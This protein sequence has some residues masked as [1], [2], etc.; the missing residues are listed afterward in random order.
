MYYTAVSNLRGF[1][2]I[3][4]NIL[5][6][7][8][9]LPFVRNYF[10]GIATIFML[11][12]VAPLEKNK[13]F[14]TERMK[15][16]PEFLANFTMELRNNG[17][18]I[19]GIDKLY[20]LLQ[21]QENVKKQIVF[22]LDDGYKDTFE[23]AYPVFKKLNVPFTVYIT[24]SFPN[25]NALLW[26]YVLEDLLLEKTE[27]EID[28]KVYR[29]QNQDE[30]NKTFLELLE[31]VSRI[32][33]QN[34]LPGLE[35]IF[36]NYKLDWFARNDELCM[37]W[38][39]IE[40]LSRDPLCTIGSHTRNHDA[41]NRLSNDLIVE[42]IIKANDELERHINRKI[43]HFAYPFGTVNEVGKREM[44]IVKKLGFKTVVTARYGSIYL[45]H[46]DYS[47]CCLPRI[48]LSENFQIKNIGRIRRK[49]FVTH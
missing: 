12:R 37:T 4:H 31:I 5:G 32:N 20:R 3:R 38:E 44:E 26:W 25:K 40:T 17:Y 46:K 48:M 8:S 33:G 28:G 45:E 13:L 24:T 16:S 14:L 42:E 36:K 10:S 11:H 43:D 21:S 30:K 41:L 49:K 9:G 35:D 7:L 1:G 22:T 6:L 47:N 39:D 29:C 2:K 15:V 23:V 19:I 18:E 27:I 34:I